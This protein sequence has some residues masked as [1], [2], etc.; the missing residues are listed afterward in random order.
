MI[1]GSIFISMGTFLYSKNLDIP[2][3]QINIIFF[4]I[5]I[6]FGLFI[7]PI[8]NTGLHNIGENI[9]GITSSMISLSRMIGMIFA[10]S[11]SYIIRPKRILR[12]ISSIFKDDSTTVVEQ[13]F[14]DFLRKSDLFSKRIK[15]FVLK[16][17]FR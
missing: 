12:T 9:R 15:P 1:L 13:R 3:D 14:K 11:I 17:F 16:V 8:H 7:V 2:T 10:Y 4:I 6:G 5:G